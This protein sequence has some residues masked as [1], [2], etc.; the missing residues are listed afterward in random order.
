MSLHISQRFQ[1]GSASVTVNLHN[2]K[3]VKS[4]VGSHGNAWVGF[5]DDAGHE[6][7]LHVDGRLAEMLADAFAKYENWLSSQEGPTF[8]DA[9]AAKCDAKAREDEARSLK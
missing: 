8:D 2:L 9:L 6:I 1:K 5:K 4:G 7:A 3:S